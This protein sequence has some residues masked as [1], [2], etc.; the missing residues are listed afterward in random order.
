MSPLDAP[1][2][3]DTVTITMGEAEQ[4]I[5]EAIASFNVAMAFETEALELDAERVRKG[6]ASVLGNPDLGF[7]LIA[8][9]TGKP[10]G[11]LMVTYEWSDWRNGMFWWIQSVYVTPEHR[12]RGI[13]RQL[14]NEVVRRAL[15]NAQV[16]GVRLY[17]EHDNHV[18][19]EVYRALG[20]SNRGYLVFETTLPTT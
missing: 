10:V 3:P 16:C 18:A 5:N 7:Y 11:C 12:G 9:I 13:Y 19:Q 20:M 17:V 2:H 6:V 15:D 14:Y 8:R 4:E 1:I